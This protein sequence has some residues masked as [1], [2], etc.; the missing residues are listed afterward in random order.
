[1]GFLD[2]VLGLMGVQVEH[3]EEPEVVPLSKRRSQVVGSVNEHL[4]Q[5]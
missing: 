4:L 1:M 5:W 3:E 2:R